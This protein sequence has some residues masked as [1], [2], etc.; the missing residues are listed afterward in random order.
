VVHSLYGEGVV[1]DSE[2]NGADEKVLIKF[3]DGNKKRF[4]VKFAPLVPLHL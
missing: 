1:V 3:S 4:M 2:G